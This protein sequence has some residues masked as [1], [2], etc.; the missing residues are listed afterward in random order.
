MPSKLGAEKFLVDHLGLMDWRWGRTLDVS[1]IPRNSTRR[2]NLFIGKSYSYR[3]GSFIH[4][5][6]RPPDKSQQP[7]LFIF[8]G[9]RGARSRVRFSWKI[10]LHQTEW[11]RKN[12][13][14]FYVLF[15]INKSTDLLFWTLKLFK[16]WIFF[17]F[18]LQG[19]IVTHKAFVIICFR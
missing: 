11:K 16:R 17:F 5:S 9:Y 19:K 13:T 7:L 18:F 12:S 4:V 1:R 8:Q 3:A 10:D 2:K 6:I 14:V 15:E